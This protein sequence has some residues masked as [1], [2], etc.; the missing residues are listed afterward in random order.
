MLGY[1]VKKKGK[2]DAIYILYHWII[3]INGPPWILEGIDSLY[4]CDTFSKR[5]N[6]ELHWKQEKALQLSQTFAWAFLGSEYVG[7]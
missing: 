3:G 2:V 7:T 4:I 5:P 6:F 1:F